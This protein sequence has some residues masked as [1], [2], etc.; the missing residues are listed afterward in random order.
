MKKSRQANVPGDDE[1]VERVD[2]QRNEQHAEEENDFDLERMAEKVAPA[3]TSRSAAMLNKFIDYLL[4][5]IGDI[6]VVI[7][8]VMRNPNVPGPYF[9]VSTA[10]PDKAW[11]CDQVLGDERDRVMFIATL[12]ERGPRV[13][14]VT[15]DELRAIKLCEILWPGDDVTNVR[16]EIE[17]ERSAG[18]TRH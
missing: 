10:G 6:H 12:A 7:T 18:I 9:I 1:V 8:P 2:E 15:E 16:G 4:V 17:L 14:H 3:S 13:V 5:D 11:R